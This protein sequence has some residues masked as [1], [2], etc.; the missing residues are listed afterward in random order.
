MQVQ[1]KN[2][3]LMASDYSQ[4]KKQSIN[5]VEKTNY[6]NSFGSAN[7]VNSPGRLEKLLISAMKLFQGPPQLT[8]EQKTQRLAEI[9]QKMGKTKSKRKL[10][11]LFWEKFALNMDVESAKKNLSMS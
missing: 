6:M 4:A 5:P 7:Q 10:E 3:S 11:N 8:L 9:E 1:F 2:T